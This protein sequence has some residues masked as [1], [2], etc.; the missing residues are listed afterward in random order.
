MFF[1]SS[2]EIRYTRAVRY[3]A[4]LLTP[5]MRFVSSC[6]Y[7]NVLTLACWGVFVLPSPGLPV[8][9][10]RCAAPPPAGW[11]SS[12]G[13]FQWWSYEEK[14]GWYSDTCLA[15]LAAGASFKKEPGG[16]AKYWSKISTKPFGLQMQ[17]SLM[18]VLRVHLRVGTGLKLAEDGFL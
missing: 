15:I 8:W 1:P 3:V 10:A 18:C 6:P 16:S 13:R 14:P 9:L 2:E 12:A 5:A 11:I 7:G 17:K 4:V